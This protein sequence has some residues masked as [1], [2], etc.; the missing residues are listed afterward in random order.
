[1]LRTLSCSIVFLMKQHVVHIALEGEGLRRHDARLNVVAGR[2]SR[3]RDREK[4]RA[5]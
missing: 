1:M 4:Q 5:S 2:K 3:G